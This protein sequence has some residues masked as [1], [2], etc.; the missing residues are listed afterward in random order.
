MFACNC[1]NTEQQIT[2]YLIEKY[3]PIGIILTGSRVS[4]NATSHSDWD[5]HIFTYKDEEGEFEGF[6]GESLE[7]TFLKL[8]VDTSFILRTTT[9]PEQHLKILYDVSDGLL[10]RIVENTRHAYAQSP[11]PLSKKQ[12][13]LY[14]KILNKYIL[15]MLSRPE[16]TGCCFFALGLFYTFAIRYWF[17]LRREWPLPPYEALP[18]ITAKDQKFYKL[19]ETIHTTSTP[20]DAK[21]LAAQQVHAQLFH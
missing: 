18:Y 7:V 15:K 13:L 10:K 2:S 12:L 8:P 3:Q 9:H 14:Q 6:R 21:I 19:L 17:E 1:M 4:G 11:Q 16:C 5:L 20:L